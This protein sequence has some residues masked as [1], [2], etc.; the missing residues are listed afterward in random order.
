MRTATSETVRALR[1][2]IGQMPYSR[3]AKD[4]GLLPV[5][6][7]SA[8]N[9][10]PMS[11]QRENTI[12]AALDMPLIRYETVQI[13]DRQRIVTRTRP[14]PGHKRRSMWVD[15]DDVDWLDA[16]ARRR[17]YRRVGDCALAA[18]LREATTIL[19]IHDIIGDTDLS[20]K[21]DYSVC[22]S[23]DLPSPDIEL[24]AIGCTPTSGNS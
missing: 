3:W 2:A 15:V 9:G 12:R 11:A 1:R 14:R 5:T 6:V 16:E 18:V 7:H 21:F 4:N 17:G 22:N 24:V 20:L 19:S 8:L 23:G 13:T 10:R